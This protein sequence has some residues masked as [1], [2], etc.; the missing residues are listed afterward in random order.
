MTRGDPDPADGATPIN[1]FKIEKQ[2]RCYIKVYG[3]FTY[4]HSFVVIYAITL[5]IILVVILDNNP[6][7][8][9]SKARKAKIAVKEEGGDFCLQKYYPL[10][11]AGP[12][13]KAI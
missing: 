3:T 4:P 13:T 12:I 9:L 1:R 11:E 8:T 2:K 7:A 10:D 6:I 5:V